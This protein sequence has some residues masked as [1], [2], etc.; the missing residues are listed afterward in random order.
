M[1]FCFL[2]EPNIFFKKTLTMLT[3][4]VPAWIIGPDQEVLKEGFGNETCL[5]GVSYV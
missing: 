4:T 2:E 5:L 1:V 3:N